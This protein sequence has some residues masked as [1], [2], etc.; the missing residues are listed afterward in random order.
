WL[1]VERPY[2]PAEDDY[3]PY[4]FN[5][6]QACRFGLEGVFIDPKTGEQRTL[7]EDI[8]AS[9]AA[10]EIHAMELE[11]E[12]AIRLLR[13][14]LAGDGNDASWIR[15]AWEREHLLP[16]VVRQQCL[17]WAGRPL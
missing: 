14:E 13:T 7:R 17:R 10:L 4:T 6:F 1:R 11:A 8:E 3:L 15:A 5:R 2:E 9:F 12:D 16:E